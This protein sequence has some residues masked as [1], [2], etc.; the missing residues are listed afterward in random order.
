[1]P[2]AREEEAIGL[3]FFTFAICFFLERIY[4]NPNHF[5]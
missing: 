2:Q 4:V 1:M 5:V 3:F